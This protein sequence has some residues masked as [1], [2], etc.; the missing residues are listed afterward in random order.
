MAPT[1]P[2]ATMSNKHAPKQTTANTSAGAV[3][4]LLGGLLK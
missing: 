3:G 1:L 4:N 2:G